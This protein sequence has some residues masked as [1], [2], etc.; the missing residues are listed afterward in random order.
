MVV[1]SDNATQPCHHL[2]DRPVDLLRVHQG[3]A[4]AFRAHHP[5][6]EPGGLGRAE[7]ATARAVELFEGPTEHARLTGS[8]DL[9]SLLEHC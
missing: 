2:G 3:R 9:V 8:V 4:A 1:Q 5:P 7:D 6:D